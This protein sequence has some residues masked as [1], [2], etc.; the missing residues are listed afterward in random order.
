MQ[1]LHSSPDPEHIKMLGNFPFTL[2]HELATGQLRQLR[3]LGASPQPWRTFLFH[4][5][6]KA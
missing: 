5:Y 3:G 4:Y 2:P 6:R 1:D